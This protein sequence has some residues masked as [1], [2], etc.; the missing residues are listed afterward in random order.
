MLTEEKVAA[1]FK[2]AGD[3][4][5]SIETNVEWLKSHLDEAYKTLKIYGKA[6]I[7]GTLNGQD[8]QGFWPNDSMAKDFGITVMKAIGSMSKDMGTVDNTTGGNL[9]SDQLATWIIQ[10]MGKFGK[11]RKYATK[12]RMGS[13]RQI[14]PKVATDLTIFCPEQGGSIEKSDVKIGLVG[15]DARKLACLTVVNRELEEDALVGLG[16]IV[17]ISITRSIAKKEDEIG[18][19]GDGTSEYFGMTGI[20]VLYSAL[21]RK[22]LQP[23]QA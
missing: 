3:R 21:M 8:Y 5:N 11:F 18:F 13:G 1:G 15:M 20:I 16:E 7:S 12:V 10:K 19:M 17:G 2:A 6:A 23:F 14:I 4:M 9:V 22:I